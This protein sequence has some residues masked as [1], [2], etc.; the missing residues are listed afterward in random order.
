MRCIFCKED[1]SASKSV[2]HIIPE[3]LGNTEHTLPRG[4]V[5]DACNNYFALKIEKPLL[6]SDYFAQTRF[7]NSVGNKR[8]KIPTIMGLHLPS[9]LAVEVSKNDEGLSIYPNR[10]KDESSFV[11]SVRASKSGKLLLPYPP[12]QESDPRIMSRFIGKVA[13]EALAQ[14]FLRIEGGIEEVT[15]DK[16]LDELRS[17]VRRNTPKTLH[18]HFHRRRI[19]PEGCVFTEHDTPYEILHEFKFLYT[20]ARELYFVMAIWGIE[21]TINMATPEIDGYVEWLNQ[22]QNRSPLMNS[23]GGF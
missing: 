21:Y 19:Y 6:D 18:W 4:V 7:R 3:S 17:Y 16:Q 5:C 12:E 20:R 10:Q 8:G 22:N 14:R 15:N 11:Q 1:S 9:R 13:I 2:E 23:D